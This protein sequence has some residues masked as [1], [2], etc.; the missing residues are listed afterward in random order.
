M[1]YTLL[2]LLSIIVCTL[3]TTQA[4]F[5]GATI[6]QEL[7]SWS[8]I[9][10][11]STTKVL[12]KWLRKNTPA[13]KLVRQAIDS[14]IIDNK[15]LFIPLKSEFT[16]DSIR[17]FASLYFG[18]KLDL[19]GSIAVD[20][21]TQD[22]IM[23]SLRQAVEKRQQTYKDKI[24]KDIIKAINTN[25]IDGKVS[26]TGKNIDQLIKELNDPYSTHLTWDE[27]R[28]FQQILYWSVS[29]IGVWV[30]KTTESYIIV[31]KVFSDSPAMEAG[32]QVSDRIIKIENHTITSADKLQDLVSQIQWPEGTSVNLTFQRWNDI[33]TKTISRKKITIDPI[34]IK[35]LNSDKVLMTIDSFQIDIYN[36]FIKK[37]KDFINYPTLVIDLRNNG[38]GSL[39]DTRAMLEHIVPQDAPIYRTVSN[40]IEKSLRSQWISPEYSLENKKIIFLTN[41]YTASAS[42]I[43]AGV[44]REYN[45]NSRIIGEQSVGKW[46]IQT[47]RNDVDGN[48]LKLTTAYRLLGK[49]KTSIQ[50]IGLTP[51]YTIIDNPLTLQDEVLDYVINNM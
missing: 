1:K 20:E 50:D 23:T 46:S 14:R 38:G 31:G 28:L 33:F 8:T 37:F 6:L 18:I 26:T 22:E 7:M 4:T 24:K 30:S 35:K 40:G 45:D 5:N 17:K 51:D 15:K 48:T 21:D 34:T 10:T 36:I 29:G 2:W 43:F 41:K 47:A 49:S 3:S 12:Y 27:N 25:A 42:E 13:Y 19:Y 16:R 9:Q 39:D 11:W 32:I 44:T